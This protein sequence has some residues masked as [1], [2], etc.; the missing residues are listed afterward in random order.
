M[1]DAKYFTTDLPDQ[2]RRMVQSATVEVLL[3]DDRVYQAYRVEDAQAGYVLLEVF[4]PEGIKPEMDST[5]DGWKLANGDR[6]A[7]PYESIAHILVTREVASNG[8]SIG[9]KP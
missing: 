7:I 5:S 8:P 1:F 3:H 2:V 9:F 4:P 6:V